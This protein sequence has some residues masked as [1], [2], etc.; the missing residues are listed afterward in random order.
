MLALDR[1]EGLRR[2]SVFTEL[3]RKRVFANR[4]S[5]LASNR[6]VDGGR[7]FHAV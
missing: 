5:F 7:P 3:S 2:I 1:G 6:L 4:F